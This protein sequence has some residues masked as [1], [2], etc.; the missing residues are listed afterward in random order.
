MET[1]IERLK[2][3]EELGH[4]NLKEA[5]MICSICGFPINVILASDGY[6]FSDS[7]NADPV[8]DG[9]CCGSCDMYVVMPARMKES[10]VYHLLDSVGLA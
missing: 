10:Q 5:D 9:R 1:A 6:A 8:N 7:R 3:Y 4:T 2:G